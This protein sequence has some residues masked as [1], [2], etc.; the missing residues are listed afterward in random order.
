MC[1]GI[2]WIFQAFFGS[3]PLS[4]AAPAQDG[5]SF[6]L[7][8]ATSVVA[9]GK[10]III[11]IISSKFFLSLWIFVQQIEIQQ[12]KGELIPEGWVQDASGGPITDP[13]QALNASLL[14]PLGGVEKNSGYKG[15]G[16]AM[17]V[18]L[19]CGILGGGW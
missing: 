4:V 1:D 2:V 8:M 18:E 17:M 11:N 15:S 7:D 9:L 16:L 5:D 12:R 6:V 10:V 3:N 13:Q 14:L 19:F